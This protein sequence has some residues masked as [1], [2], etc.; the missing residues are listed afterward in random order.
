MLLDNAVYKKDVEDVVQP[1]M[2][3]WSRFQNKWILITG[4]TGLIGSL[5]V[6]VFLTA[7]E[8]MHLGIKVSILVRSE[9]KARKLFGAAAA[10]MNIMVGSVEEF[11]D[12]SDDVDYIIHA[13]SQTSSKG[14]VEQPVETFMTS[15]KGTANLLE[16]ARKKQAEKLIYL[17]TMEVYG[18]P[19][20][21]D[22]IQESLRTSVL[23]SDIRNCYPISKIASENLCCNYFSEYGVKSA[24]LRLTQTFGP[25]VNYHDGRVFAEF[26]RCAIEGRDIILKTKGETK[27][28]YLYTTDAITAI[29]CLL[30]DE[31][32]QFEIYNAA[33]EE[34]YCSIFEMA[35]LA[36]Q[37][38][39]IHVKIEEQFD[40]SK[41]GYAPTLHM[42][43]DTTKL[44]SLG[45]KPKY[46]LS[47]M[48]DRLILFMRDSH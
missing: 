29:L 28:S 32:K 39:D 44:K 16:I 4:A 19:A 5:L 2:V 33:N 12:V 24:V 17:S 38:G 35:Q 13:A 15:I 20:T 40:L 41:F 21:D 26:A 34:T 46:D 23:S 30:S 6:N 36:A 9:E 22:K 1:S 43:L 14:F 37:K 7:N 10:Q 42:N 11:T 27:R 3:D 18:L 8:R 25:G 47:E 45:W 31:I 48:F